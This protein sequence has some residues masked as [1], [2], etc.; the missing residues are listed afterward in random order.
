MINTVSVGL[1]R[2]DSKYALSNQ[3]FNAHK[4]RDDCKTYSDED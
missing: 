3:G 2:K 4:V 1:A